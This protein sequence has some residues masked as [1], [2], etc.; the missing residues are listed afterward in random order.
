MT[1]ID[2]SDVRHGVKFLIVG[3]LLILSAIIRIVAARLSS[4][5]PL[6]KIPSVAAGLVRVRG[7]SV[8]HNSEIYAPFSGEKCDMYFV[9][10]STLWWNVWSP[11]F[12]KGVW[13]NWFVTDGKAEIEIDPEEFEIACRRS[14]SKIL[15]WW[16]DDPFVEKKLLDLGYEKSSWFISKVEESVISRGD[17]IE[18]VASANPKNDGLILGHGAASACTIKN[19]ERPPRMWTTYLWLAFGVL[20]S[21][22]GFH[23]VGTLSLGLTDLFSQAI[24]IAGGIIMVVFFIAMVSRIK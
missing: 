20:L 21:A 6:S 2:P 5:L 9:C 19:M 24:A 15:W 8:S 14:Y 18:I 17:E 4:S 13:K 10:V 23:I 7:R 22:W 11:E 3:P 12:S 1:E 16:T